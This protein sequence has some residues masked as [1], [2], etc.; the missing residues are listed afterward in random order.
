M[1]AGLAYPGAHYQLI[2]RSCSRSSWSR[3]RNPPPCALPPSRSLA[4]RAT[5]ARCV[6][7]RLPQGFYGRWCGVHIEG[8][9]M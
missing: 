4:S 3:T 1:V 2:P 5:C 6:R 7:S 8:M 9:G